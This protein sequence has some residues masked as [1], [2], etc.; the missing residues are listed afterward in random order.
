LKQ[1]TQ[2]NK[3][4]TITEVLI[5]IVILSLSYMAISIAL[6][7]GDR[8]RGRAKIVSS[9]I[10]LAQNEIEHIRKQG[11]YNE[12]ISDSSYEITQ[13]NLTFTLEKEVV[14]GQQYHY[15]DTL[16]TKEILIKVYFQN[17]GEEVAS[18]RLLQGYY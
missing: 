12:L 11:R 5:A 8:V 2:N 18:F 3:G 7:G 13:N 16:K 17:T 4:L 6:S 14:G 1:L 10:T 9:A 15:E